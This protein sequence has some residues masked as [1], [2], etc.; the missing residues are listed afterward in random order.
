MRPT[1]IIFTADYVDP[2]RDRAPDLPA[3]RQLVFTDLDRAVFQIA[4]QTL[5][6]VGETEK[7]AIDPMTQM[8]RD[9]YEALVSG[10]PAGDQ[11]EQSE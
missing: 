7:R 11:G 8:T 2:P 6:Y 5:A 4:D 3:L 10:R 9:Y 1:Q